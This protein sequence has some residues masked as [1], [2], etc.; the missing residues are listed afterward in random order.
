MAPHCRRLRSWLRDNRN[1]HT[2]HDAFA[3]ISRVGGACH[4]RKRSDL[5]CELI[6]HSEVASQ[7]AFTPF[8]LVT[9]LERLEPHVLAFEDHR[10][11]RP[12]REHEQEILA[13]LANS[14]RAPLSINLLVLGRRLPML[15]YA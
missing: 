13:M 8:E 7:R 12:F 2:E 11:Y 4:D 3:A 10:P 1:A 6:L 5:R 14:E 15:R 9:L